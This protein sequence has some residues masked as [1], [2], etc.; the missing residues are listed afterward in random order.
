MRR[1]LGSVLCKLLYTLIGDLLLIN[2]LLGFCF[3]F[4]GCAGR[5]FF[6]IHDFFEVGGIDEIVNVPVGVR[7]DRVFWWE[8]PLPIYDE[9]IPKSTQ[10][11]WWRPRGS[12]Y[13]RHY[14]Y[15]CYRKLLSLLLQGYRLFPLREW[16]RQQ[17][18]VSPV[19][20]GESL[21]DIRIFHILLFEDGAAALYLAS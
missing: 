17:D 7:D 4:F 9:L 16:S 19:V 13:D 21:P 5:L 3:L 14:M 1:H 20:P 12:C 10:E 11:H 15:N 6:F 2:F 8:A 18:L